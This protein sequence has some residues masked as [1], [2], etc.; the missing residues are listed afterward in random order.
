MTDLIALV[1]KDTFNWT[2]FGYFDAK[3]LNYTD[4][5][6]EGTIHMELDYK[7]S[8]EGFEGTHGVRLPGSPNAT[9]DLSQLNL[10]NNTNA[11]WPYNLF[12][13]SINPLPP[14]TSASA[15]LL[16]DQASDSDRK[17]QGGSANNQNPDFF[18]NLNIPP[19]WRS[20]IPM[21]GLS[22]IIS[23]VIKLI[24]NALQVFLIF[25][26]PFNDKWRNRWTLWCASSLQ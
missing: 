22:E 1:H 20:V 26:R 17:L 13:N 8:N 14:S 12:Q 24:I 19:V 10:M 7:S 2:T 11:T 23:S 6:E 25:L 3:A 4:A 16:E 15:R 5:W 18:K 21:E 9:V